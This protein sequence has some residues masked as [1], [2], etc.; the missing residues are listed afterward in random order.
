MQLE[1]QSATINSMLGTIGDGE[2]VPQRQGLWILF[3]VRENSVHVDESLMHS[4]DNNV[5]RNVLLGLQADVLLT[6]QL[7]NP[8]VQFQ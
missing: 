2:D 1:W 4:M 3:F 5:Y 8:P 7:A 6:R